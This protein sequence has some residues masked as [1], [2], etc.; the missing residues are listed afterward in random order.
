MFFVE[1]LLFFLKLGEKYYLCVAL[2]GIVSGR[3][4]EMPQD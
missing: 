1:F 2:T 4:A 3:M